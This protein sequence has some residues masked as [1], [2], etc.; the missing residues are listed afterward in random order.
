MDDEEVK[1]HTHLSTPIDVG[2]PAGRQGQWTK[3]AAL[4]TNDYSVTMSALRDGVCD[5]KLRKF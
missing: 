4:T 5:E 1:N 2:R 3:Q